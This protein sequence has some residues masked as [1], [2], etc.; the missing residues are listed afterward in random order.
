[1]N[2]CPLA[3]SVFVATGGWE[4]QADT[5]SRNAVGGGRGG[6]KARFFGPALSQFNKAIFLSNSGG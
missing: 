2:S 3:C 6:G 1:M 4:W 5:N